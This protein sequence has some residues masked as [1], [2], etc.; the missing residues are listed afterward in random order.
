MAAAYTLMYRSPMRALS[1][2]ITTTVPRCPTMSGRAA[3]V[4]FIVPVSV[5]PTTR[6]MSAAV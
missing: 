1:E 5:T 2:L 4:T 6:S 3:W